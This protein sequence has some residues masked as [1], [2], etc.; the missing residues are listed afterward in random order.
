M[1][2]QRL[3]C[4]SREAPHAVC[5][6]CCGLGRCIGQD[7]CIACNFAGRR[8][9][10]D[11]RRRER[12]NGRLQAG[13]SCVK[14]L[15]LYQLKSLINVVESFVVVSVQRAFL[16]TNANHQEGSIFLELIRTCKEPSPLPTAITLPELSANGSQIEVQRVFLFTNSNHEES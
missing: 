9:Y 6:A 14:S 12:V 10:S 2:F 13:E 5:F 1:T 7:Q 11:R 15:P 16:S 3:I 8:L 4:I